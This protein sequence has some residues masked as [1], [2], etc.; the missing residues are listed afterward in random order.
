VLNKSVK[1]LSGM[2]LAAAALGFSAPAQAEPFPTKG[3]ILLSQLPGHD[4]YAPINEQ[5]SFD[6]LAIGRVRGKVGSIIQ[7]QLLPYS[8]AG[9]PGYIQAS[10][11]RRIYRWNGVGDAEPGD[12]VLLYPVFDD[13]GNYIRTEFYDVAHPSWLTRLDLKQVQEVTISEINFQ[14]SEPV[15]LPPVTRT[16]PAPVAPAPA[17]APA[18]GPIRGL[19]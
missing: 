8:Y 6:G 18:P 10:D 4:M 17:P 14:T 19:W 15:G 13:N 16:A 11:N 2:L 7:V 3:S 9:F 5:M 1:V 12:D